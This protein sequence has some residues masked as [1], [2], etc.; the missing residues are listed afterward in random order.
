M[1]FFTNLFDRLVSE[2]KAYTERAEALQHIVIVADDRYQLIIR[3]VN[4]LI[5]HVSLY[6]TLA[7]VRKKLQVYK[8]TLENTHKRGCLSIAREQPQSGNFSQL[9]ENLDRWP[10]V[11]IL[12]QQTY[13][14]SLKRF[15]TGPKH[16]PRQ[17]IR[18][19]MSCVRPL[20]CDMECTIGGISAKIN[21]PPGCYFPKN[22]YLCTS[23]VSE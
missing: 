6:L 13:R 8:L 3:L 15:K 9:G 23:N 4:F 20:A 7:K 19:P 22:S 2:T 1:F 5:L 12:L 17:V 21:N 18:A 11:E 14:F 16:H 10:P